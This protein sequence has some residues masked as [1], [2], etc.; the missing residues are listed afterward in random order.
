MS[1]RDTYDAPR[2]GWC[3]FHCGER[4]PSTTSGQEEARQHFG[5]TPDWT[6]ECLERRT[7]ETDKLV[8]LS[9]EA[10]LGERAMI[11]RALAAEEAE[12]IAVCKV[13][14]ARAEERVNTMWERQ[15]AKTAEAQLAHVRKHAPAAWRAAWDSVVGGEPYPVAEG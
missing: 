1:E 4:F 2:H 14:G 10:R 8:R 5:P 15:R 12:E 6:P 9:R 13:D 11:D 7:L 3:C